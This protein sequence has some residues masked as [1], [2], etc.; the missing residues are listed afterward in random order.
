MKPPPSSPA[1]P[2]AAPSVAASTIGLIL[3]GGGARAAYQAGVLRAIAR[4]LPPG[5]P[6]P[7]RVVCGTSAG[8]VNAA[9]IAAGAAD[10]DRATDHLATTW[11]KLHV[12]DVYRADLS[13]VLRTLGRWF[14]S[15]FFRGLRL[16]QRP[17]ALL[18]NAPL[19]RLLERTID[20][21][22]IQ[23]AIDG[24]HLDAVCVTTSGY[25][26]GYSLSFF[27][28][29][30]GCEPWQRA[31]RIGTAASIGAREVMASTAIPFVFP[32]VELAHEYCGD[33]SMQQLAPFSPALHLGADRVLA[34]GVGHRRGRR[35][36][37]ADPQAFPSLADIAG[38]LLDCVFSDTLEIDL[39][40]L[41]RINHTVGL[42]PQGLRDSRGTS[43]RRIETLL[44]S[45]SRDLE[46][47]AIEYAALLPRPVRFLLRCLGASATR[48]GNLLGYLLFEG[49]FCAEVIALGHDDAMARR[50]EILAFLGVAAASAD[51]A[52]APARRNP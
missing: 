25:T 17:V 4:M 27:Q 29:R 23:P 2:P 16:R 42:L 26:S 3:T 48:S 51:A 8:A 47:I 1:P 35:L 32:P 36:P 45:P 46:Q 15:L 52:P 6:N 49:A 41:E 50:E 37:E 19:R 33:G 18:D 5:A 22:A 38:R 34:I 39:E 21:A 14:G 43:L 20:F 10:F 24:G 7:F 13:D 12:G 30:A 44:L 28:G 40:R 31:R 11:S 9:A